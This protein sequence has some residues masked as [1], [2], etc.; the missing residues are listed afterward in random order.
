ML[1]TEQTNIFLIYY[2]TVSV[3]LLNIQTSDLRSIS[4]T[5][6]FFVFFL[7][8]LLHKEKRWQSFS[9]VTINLA[10][11]TVRAILMFDELCAGVTLL[12]HINITLTAETL[13][14]K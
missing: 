5:Q 2:C 12:F 4:Q 8:T 6:G 11:A 10:F 3:N 7:C 9:L 13:I 14:Y 1:E